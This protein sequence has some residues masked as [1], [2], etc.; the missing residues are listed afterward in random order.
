MSSSSNRRPRP[1][2]SR[3]TCRTPQRW[4]PAM[5]M[6][7]TC[8]RRTA[9]FS[10][11][12]TSRW[13]GPSSATRRSASTRSS[14][15]CATPSGSSSRPTP[16]A[17]ARRSPG[18]CSRSSRSAS[19]LKDVEVKRVVFHEITKRAVTEAMAHPRDLDQSLIDAYLARR[20]LDYLVG[21]TLSP[22]LWRKLPGL[23]LGRPRAV[24]GAAADLRARGRDRGLRAARVLDGRGAAR[25]ARSRPSS[26]PG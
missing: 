23:A 2:P 15:P 7:A 20:A 1:R 26:R 16:T 12:T 14:K 3:S 21:F 9:R 8:W 6:S 11:T 10:P 13:S 5:A 22:V 17:R 4:R 19:V 24:G 18:T 25:D